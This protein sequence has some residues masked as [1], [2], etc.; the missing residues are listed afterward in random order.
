MSAVLEEVM[1]DVHAA[2]KRCPMTKIVDG[3]GDA[4]REWITLTIKMRMGWE[5][6]VGESRVFFNCS[7]LAGGEIYD[8]AAC[9]GPCRVKF[10]T[11]FLVLDR[12]KKNKNHIVASMCVSVMMTT[13][14]FLSD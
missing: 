13:T 7:V 5:R 4:A 2:T 6:Q 8:V 11:L 10:M 14:D 1:A 12:V 9:F 3:T